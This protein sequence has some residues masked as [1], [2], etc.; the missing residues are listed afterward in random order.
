MQTNN[1]LLDDL[2]QLLGGAAGVMAG[3]RSEA[4]ALL[5]DRLQ[6]L[7][8]D[9]RLV[10]REEFEAVR[11]MAEKARLDQADLAAR[12]E[13]LEARLRAV[14]PVAAPPSDE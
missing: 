1:R 8:D 7:L 4:E 2:A 11:A 10:G 9:M 3:A 12:L 6:R 5:K 13:A 14:E